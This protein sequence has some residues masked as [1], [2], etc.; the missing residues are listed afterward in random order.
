MTE[1]ERI[2]AMDVVE[3]AIYLSDLQRKAINDFENGFYPKGI[4]DTVEELEAEAITVKQSDVP[5][6]DS[7]IH[8]CEAMNKPAYA[9]QNGNTD[10]SYVLR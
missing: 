2:K 1:F 5:A 6:L 7:V 3:L 4:F 8:S 10:K 9:N